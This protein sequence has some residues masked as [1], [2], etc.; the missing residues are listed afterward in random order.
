LILD[1][2]KAALFFLLIGFL[3]CATL[4]LPESKLLAE[5][6][7]I[8]FRS[9]H[10]IRRNLWFFKIGCTIKSVDSFAPMLNNQDYLVLYTSPTSCVMIQ[11]KVFPKSSW[12]YRIF[13]N[14]WYHHFSFTVIVSHFIRNQLCYPKIAIG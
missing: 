12:I 9:R 1:C 2:A 11:P 4:F 7:R 5:N 3:R 6:I 14:F 8:N 10:H 13:S